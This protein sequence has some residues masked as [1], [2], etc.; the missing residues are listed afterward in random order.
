MTRLLTLTGAGGSGRPRLALE[1]TRD[2]VSIYPDGVWQ[3]EL[4]GLSE[5][6]LV[7]QAIARA[8]RVREQ[9]GQILRHA[10]RSLTREGNV[11][12]LGQ[13]RTPGGLGSPAA[14]YSIGLVRNLRVL[15]TSQEVLSV[16]GEVIWQV[17]PSRCPT[18]IVCPQ[19]R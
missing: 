17:S 1:V 6:G 9:P 10:H 5:G 16:A 14:G 19:G 15:A 11:A 13:L 18:L 3:V 2:L 12:S 7:A 8:L 4:A